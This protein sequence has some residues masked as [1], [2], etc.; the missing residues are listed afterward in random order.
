MPREATE[1]DLDSLAHL[2]TLCFPDPWP[3][4]AFE[5]ELQRATTRIFV[6]GDPEVRAYAFFQVVLDEAEL[7]RLATAPKARRQG[8]G[9][10]LL[11]HGIR[12]LSR[13]GV[14]R[15]FLEVRED[16]RAARALYE[17]LGFHLEGRRD[18]Y[19]RDG[20]DALLY[21]R[22]CGPGTPDLA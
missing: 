3:R 5:A 13:G 9:A 22:G 6:A 17:G 19:Y 15:L 1:E 16:N 21:A 11:E 12:H 20:E 4:D 7:L 8:L 18:G 10:A 2:E 14:R